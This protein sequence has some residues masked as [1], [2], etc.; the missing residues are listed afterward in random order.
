MTLTQAEVDQLKNYALE[1]PT[2]Y[3]VQLLQ[4]IAKKEQDVLHKVSSLEQ[5]R[6][7]LPKGE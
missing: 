4:F 2:K 3:G 5:P 7:P 1:L 6:E